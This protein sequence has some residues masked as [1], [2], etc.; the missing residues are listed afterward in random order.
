MQ[1]KNTFTPSGLAELRDGKRTDQSLLNG[2]GERRDGKQILPGKWPEEVQPSIYHSSLR[3]VHWVTI[4]LRRKRR[5]PELGAVTPLKARGNERWGLCNMNKPEGSITHHIAIIK[6]GLGVAVIDNTEPM[7]NVMMRVGAGQILEDDGPG[8]GGD[9]I[10]IRL[11]VEWN[12]NAS[13]LGSCD[14]SLLHA[15]AIPRSAARPTYT[16]AVTTYYT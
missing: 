16:F 15:C 6:E 4:M 7:V 2:K 8:E 11:A 5:A 12:V 3:N 14:A 1:S 10:K 13:T 9:A